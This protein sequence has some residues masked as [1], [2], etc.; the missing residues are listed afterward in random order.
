MKK[1]V[2]CEHCGRTIY[3]IIGTPIYGE[4]VQPHM[5]Q[6]LYGNPNPVSG[7]LIVCPRCGKDLRGSMQDAVGMVIV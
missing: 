3:K 2:V 4:V 1:R 7:Q 5:F 6:G